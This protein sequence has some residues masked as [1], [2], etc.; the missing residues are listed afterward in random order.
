MIIILVKKLILSPLS[1]LLPPHAAQSYFSLLFSFL[2]LHSSNCQAYFSLLKEGTSSPIFDTGSP[3]TNLTSSPPSSNNLERSNSAREPRSRQHARPPNQTPSRLEPRF[4][5]QFGLVR[6]R[7]IILCAF[8]F[9][10]FH[11]IAGL[12]FSW[13][14]KA[15]VRKR[16]ETCGLQEDDERRGTMGL[17]MGLQLSVCGWVRET[18][19][20]VFLAVFDGGALWSARGR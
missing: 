18:L 6:D 19:H 7:I 3:K 14:L 17:E 1:S 11:D 16:R 12:G 4:R 15:G 20:W 8:A 5:F 9:L 2:L 13:V 10:L